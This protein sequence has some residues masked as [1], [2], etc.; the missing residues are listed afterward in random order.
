M[1]DQIGIAL[2]GVAAV[3]LTQSQL[4]RRRR[5]ACLFGL[6]GQPFWFYSSIAAEQWGIVAVSVL[7]AVA[8]AKGAR[9]Y[10]LCKPEP[11]RYA[12]R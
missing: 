12:G 4:E 2:T 6:A 10:W 7:Y 8:W 3:F 9:Q 5:Y 1:I 11:A